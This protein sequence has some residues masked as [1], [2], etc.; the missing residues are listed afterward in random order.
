MIKDWITIWGVWECQQSM[1]RTPVDSG[2][3]NNIAQIAKNG[4]NYI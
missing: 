4:I 1:S 2:M 3:V